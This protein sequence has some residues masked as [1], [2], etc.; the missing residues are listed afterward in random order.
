VHAGEAKPQLST[1]PQH[2]TSWQEQVS[3]TLACISG[4]DKGTQVKYSVASVGGMNEVKKLLGEMVQRINSEQQRLGGGIDPDKSSIVPVVKLDHTHYMH[5]KWGKTYTPVITI[6]RWA[7]LNGGQPE[8]PEPAP[9]PQAAAA[10][11]PRT[12]SRQRA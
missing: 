2:P 5:K 4:E 3:L 9:A 7:T 11:A 1:L 12:R 6:L 8:Q 10:D